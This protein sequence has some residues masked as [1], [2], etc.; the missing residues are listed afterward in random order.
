[1]DGSDES[2]DEYKRMNKYLADTT[3]IIEHLRGN[4]RAKNFLQKYNPSISTVTIA[5]LIQGARDKRELTSVTKICSSLSEAAIDKKV[6][7]KA[8]E[9]L[10]DFYLSHGLLFL[11][12]LIAATA[13]ENKMILVTGNIKHFKNIEDLQVVPQVTAF[14]G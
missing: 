13:L 11:D 1:M 2:K 12:A 7:R 3:V 14:K 10:R 4:L 9:L 6:S 8:I 5:E